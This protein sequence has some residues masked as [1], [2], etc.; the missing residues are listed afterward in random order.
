MKGSK[1][2]NSCYEYDNVIECL[3][4]IDITIVKLKKVDMILVWGASL[5]Y[6]FAFLSGI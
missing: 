4:F 1:G 3:W 2:N 6:Q 5:S